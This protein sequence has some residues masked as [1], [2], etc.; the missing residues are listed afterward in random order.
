MES[1]D[2]N[3]LAFF[4]YIVNQTH[5]SHQIDNQ[6]FYSDAKTYVINKDKISYVEENEFG[7][8]IQ[9]KMTIKDLMIPL[10]YRNYQQTKNSLNSF[11]FQ[12]SQKSVA[13]YLRIQ[14]KII[15]NIVNRQSELL[16][17][18]KYLLLPIRG[19][20]NYINE[21]LIFSDMPDF[22]LDESSISK[23]INKEDSLFDINQQSDSQ[24]I[25]SIIDYMNGLNEKREQI[26]NNVDFELLVK[27][28]KELISKEKIPSFEKQ[29][30]PK[31]SNGHILI[32][33]WVL[34]KELYTT[35]R[36]R[37]YFYDFIKAVF[38]SFNENELSSIKSQFGTKVRVYNHDFLP[39]TIK[40]HLSRD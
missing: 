4:E 29:L 20:V 2:K 18:N 6:L 37:P 35:K 8:Y 23:G 34:H 1:T 31:L 33:Y 5:L 32:S 10:L 24:V 3:P 27:Y 19:L 40:K 7:E 36:I 26:L 39:E 14:F 28:T 21:V 38:I 17:N 16:N 13:N 11:C 30:N 25:H 22:V 12:N 15:Q 9:H